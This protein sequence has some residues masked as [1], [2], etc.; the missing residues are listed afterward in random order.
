MLFEVQGNSGQINRG[1]FDGQLQFLRSKF[2]LVS[3]QSLLAREE[4]GKEKRNSLV[5]FGQKLM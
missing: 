4:L 2:F 3:V 1:Q 5:L